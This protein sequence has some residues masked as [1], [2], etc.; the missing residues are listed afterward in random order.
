MF[1]AYGKT[2]A[3]RGN[4]NNFLG[5]VINLA[6]M[7]SDIDYAVFEMGMRRSGDIEE[8][9]KIVKPAIAILTSVSFAHLEFFESNLGIAH[10]KCEIFKELDVNTGMAILNRDIDLF[11]ICMEHIVELKLKNVVTYGKANDVDVKFISF[12]HA[13]R[14]NVLLHYSVKTNQIKILMPSIPSH[15]AENFG[16]GLAIIEYLKLDFTQAIN[17]IKSFLPVMGRGNMVDVTTKSNIHRLICDYYNSSPQSLKASLA[18]L[19]AINGPNK[20]AIL[21][22]MRELGHRAIEFHKEIVPHIIDSNVNQ[23][24]LVGEIIKTI[25]E[26][27]PKTILISCF[28]NTDCLL[29]QIDALIKVNSIILIKGS[30]SL[31]LEKVARYFG[32]ITC[33]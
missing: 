19:A 33:L 32:L 26:H 10:A 12:E 22:D 6:S 1:E 3:S 17:A 20:I 4:F 13:D 29:D 8:L 7:P 25:V 11:D 27:L 30:R 18:W 21:G 28:D 15:L 16:P 24:I 14:D 5:T 9:V 23:L 31:Q 2:F